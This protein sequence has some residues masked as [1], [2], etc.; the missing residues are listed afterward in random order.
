MALIDPLTSLP[1]HPTMMDHITQ[2]LARCQRTQERSAVVFVDLDHFKHINDA[3]GH[4]AGDAV[5]RQ[6]GRRL[7]E[8]IHE[9]DVVGRYGGEEFVLVLANTNL[10]EAKRTA[11]RLRAAFAG[12]PCLISSEENPQTQTVIPVTASIG[13]AIF[14]EHG[15]TREALIEAADRAMYY[16]KQTGRNR[17]CIAGEET[18][19]TS[20]ILATLPKGKLTEQVAIQTLTAVA[21]TH[22]GKTSAHAHRL[23]TLT[24]ATARRLGR[25]EE[26]IH[27]VRLAALFHDLGKIGIPDSILHKQGPLTEE[28][29]T[30]MRRHPVLGQHILV[31]VG[32]IFE[33]LS[34]IVVAHHE[35]WDGRGY[36][37]GLAQS[38]IPLGARILSV[39][40][41]Y[42]A[43]TSQ[44]PYRLP[45][46]DA[47]ARAEL[48]RCAGGQF[49]PQVVE[50]FLQVLD[51]T[52]QPQAPVVMGEPPRD[53]TP[54]PAAGEEL[55]DREAV[56]G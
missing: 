44:R 8:N 9:Q 53:A 52:E 1:N 49:D 11:E 26:E 50:V 28:E 36:P 25:S 16:A 38:A 4:Q 13:V 41:S 15:T 14:Q 32:G 30:V 24:E 31:Q 18:A 42:D 6:A 29:W 2:E 54:A 21:D 47:Q 37:H 12:E 20:Q 51:G 22:D 39:V 34:H 56:R 5:L 40:D 17:I 7:K 48:Q 43:M 33:L 27:L 19:L 46:S 10:S 35:R 3:W 45:L 55:L 23:V